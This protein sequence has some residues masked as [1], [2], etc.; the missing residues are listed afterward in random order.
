[1]IV[2]L[3]FH[4]EV[5]AGLKVFLKCLID[6]PQAHSHSFSFLTDDQKLNPLFH[7]RFLSLACHREQTL[8]HFLTEEVLLNT[9][10]NFELDQPQNVI[11]NQDNSYRQMLIDYNPMLK[12]VIVQRILYLNFQRATHLQYKLQQNRK[13]RSCELNILPL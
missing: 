1:L 4:L 11:E 3:T 9:L 5:I 8:N 2:F 10:S 6:K 12:V 7:V 13:Y